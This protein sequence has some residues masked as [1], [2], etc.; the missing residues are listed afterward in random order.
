MLFSIYTFILLLLLVYIGLLCYARSIK[1]PS[2]F[3]KPLSQRLQI[4]SDQ[5]QQQDGTTTTGTKKHAALLVAHRGGASNYA[6]ENTVYACEKSLTECS[7]G[8]DD[9]SD[10]TLID[11]IE[12][13]IRQTRDKH[14]ILHHNATVDATGNA[15]GKVCDF[16]LAELKQ[17]NAAYHFKSHTNNEYSLRSSGI[18]YATLEEVLDKFASKYKDLIFFLDFKESNAVVPTFELMKK[19]QLL[20]RCITG[21]VPPS[22]N[23]QLLATFAKY[24]PTIPVTT[25]IFTSIVVLVAYYLGLLNLVPLKHDILGFWMGP[26]VS[27]LVLNANFFNELIEKRG[28]WVGL[29][30]PYMDDPIIQEQCLKLGGQLLVVDTPT[31]LLK[32]MQKL[33]YKK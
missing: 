25:D 1:H 15:T 17:L 20:H 23:R 6:P 12:I 4:I 21:S 13:D 8:T 24:D 32:V 30:G 33:Q 16:T 29:F 9:S 31:T 14:L 7:S 22:S 28:R 11:A 27:S 26:V 10:N 2:K 18:Q 5:Q 19:K 3:D